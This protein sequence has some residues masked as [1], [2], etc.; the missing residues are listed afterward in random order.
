MDIAALVHSG[1]ALKDLPKQ[2]L[3]LLLGESAV[4]L[5]LA[6]EITLITILRNDVAV[7]RAANDIVA[8]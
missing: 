3:K 7:V 6:G 1:V 8:L 2:W 4:L 5:Q